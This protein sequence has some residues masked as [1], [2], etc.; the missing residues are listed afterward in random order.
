M[1]DNQ[2][3][4]FFPGVNNE[5]DQGLFS[6]L[7]LPNRLKVH[8]FSV[9]FDPPSFDT[10]DWTQQLNAGTIALISG[11]GGLLALTSAVSAITSQEALTQSFQLAKGF[12][13]WFKTS[14]SVDAVLGLVLVGMLN[15]TATPFTPASQTDGIIFITDNTGALSLV[16]A[17]G[18]VRL[19]VPL[20]VSLVAGQLANLGWYYD[21]GCY[22]SAP[23]GR[24]IWEVT[25]PGVTAK[26]RGEVLI[27][28]AGTIAAFP[29]AVNIG[30]AMGVSASTAVARVL[31]VDYLY[32]AK[33]RANINAT[34]SF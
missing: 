9:D 6:D 8:E 34:P 31:T 21:G 20:G 12:R 28:A 32:A 22:A 19:V 23:L 30:P 14:L 10:T 18:G 27:P 11:D 3:T 29:G 5:S 15:A 16:V 25:G 1:L 33:D 7:Y 26:A 17:V 4:R 24:I 2:V 13:T